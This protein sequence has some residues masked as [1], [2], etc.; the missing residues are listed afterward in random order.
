MTDEAIQKIA[1]RIEETIT[2]S[3]SALSKTYSD[4]QSETISRLGVIDESIK[5][6]HRRQDITNGRIAHT[7]NE[8]IALKENRAA[9]DSTLKSHIEYE[10]ARERKQ[11][12]SSAWWKQQFG[13][14]AFL[15]VSG[16]FIY[17]L[18]KVNKL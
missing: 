5:G 7:E 12:T 14:W 13:W 17:M 10:E 4:F 1:D 11:D 8:V 6:I 18:D 15:L 9:M 2:K 3:H 16:T